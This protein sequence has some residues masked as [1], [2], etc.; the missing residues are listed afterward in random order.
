M[1]VSPVSYERNR[2]LFA[3]AILISLCFWGTPAKASLD[4]SKAITQYV[5]KAWGGESG[6]PESSV[7]A[8]AQTAD[9]YLWLGTENGLFRFDGSTF[10]AFD[11]LNTPELGDNSITALHVDRAGI[12]WIGTAGRGIVQWKNG[13]FDRPQSQQRSHDSITSFYES[14]SGQIWAGTDGNGVIVFNE[15]TPQRYTTSSGLPDNSVFA[16]TGNAAGRLWFATQAGISELSDGRFLKSISGGRVQIG[17]AT[18]LLCDQSGTLW[19]GTRR[20]GLYRLRDGELAHLGPESGLS[21]NAISSIYQDKAGTLWIGTLDNGVNRLYGGSITSLNVKNGFSSGGVWTIFEDRAGTVWLGGTE[22]GLSCLRQ[23]SVTPVGKEEGLET[24]T[25]LGLYEDRE[26]AVW[27]GSDNGVTVWKEGAFRTYTVENGLPDNLVFAIAQDGDGRMWAGTRRGLAHF[28]KYRF[29]PLGSTNEPTL[30]RP[31]LSLLPAR[32]GSIWAGGRGSL[33]H[34]SRTGVRIYTTAD[35]LPNKIIMSL[36]EDG[37]GTIWIGTEGAGLLRFF[38]GKFSAAGALDGFGAGSICSILGDRDGTLWLGTRGGGL[39]RFAHGVFTAFTRRAGLSDDD[40]F[41]ILEDRVGRLWLSSNKGISSVAKSE[42]NAFADKRISS[43]SSRLYGTSDGMRSRECNG[44]FQY[45]GLRDSDGRLWFPTV[46]GIVSIDPIGVSHPHPPPPVVIEGIS[47]GDNALPLRN[48][49]VVPART[50]Q[51]EFRFTS[52]YFAGADALNFKYYLDGF[53]KQW[54]SAEGRRVANYTNLPPGDY[55]FRVM[56]CA[57]GVCTT[58]ATD[59]NLTLL[60]AWYETKAFFAFAL[61]FF[62]GSIHGAHKLHVRQLKIRERKLQMLVAE[63]TSELQESRDQLES[64]VALR[65]KELSNAN[66]RLETE[67][68]VRRAAEQKAE[69][70]NHAKSEFVTNMSHELRT[71]MNGVI[72]MTNL[73]LQMCDNPMQREYLE[74]VSQSADHLLS[75]LN[76]ILD[77]SKI[78]SGKLL[79]EETEFDL[80]ELIEKLCRTLR[81]LAEQK[82]VSLNLHLGP[83]VP[84]YVM[85]DPTRLRQVLL[86]LVG[87]GIKFTAAGQVELTVTRKNFNQVHFRV[88]DTG[89]GIAKEKQQSIFES[90]VQADGG[91][92]R[93]FGGTGLGL[94]I[95]DR[96]VRLLGGGVIQVESE[97]GSGSVFSFDI[98]VKEIVTKANEP[99][100][101]LRQLS[102]ALAAPIQAKAESPDNSRF[103]VLVAEDNPVNQKLAKAI[104]QKAGYSVTLVND[105][106]EAV[107]ALRTA[108]YDLVLMDVQM[109]GMDGLAATQAIR[110]AEEGRKH[111]PIIALTAHAIQGDREKCLKAGMDE[112]LTKPINVKQLMARIASLSATANTNPALS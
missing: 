52:P 55:R 30:L 20:T 69:A 108:D 97:L 22:S 59:T 57:K 66:E 21:S 50:K 76:D 27:I 13:K 58:E 74:L 91:T 19:I 4:P 54:V 11:R 64:R 94:A 95:S 98:E 75:V 65:T 7:M 28:D 25:V 112:Y 3:L 72:G 60:P 38:D 92:A 26:K 34:V 16:I 79:L 70:A 35:G 68:S 10:K 53:D 5:H 110:A 37:D 85:A 101:Q 48:P 12:L 51:V 47:A 88:S 67:V 71:P 33:T 103:K 77:F 100:R 9:S 93:K 81:P 61:L 40:V 39:I 89:I 99:A 17:E 44:G 87:N 42:L 32:D 24:D 109:P 78:E 102:D 96:L 1:V 43:V 2:A 15:G 18:A 36:F 41:A 111:T 105:G 14:A 8:V 56:A 90:F 83:D 29:V 104:L 46:K 106:L 6:L 23:G 107:A 82:G 49:V 86:N 62:L 63:R 45:A 73:A 80:P 84:R 31:T